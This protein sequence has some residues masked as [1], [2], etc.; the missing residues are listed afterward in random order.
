MGCAAKVYR[1][2][3][4]PVGRLAGWARGPQLAMAERMTAVSARR[5]PQAASVELG[6]E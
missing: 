3:G 5:G 1:L 4:W 6:T 2:A